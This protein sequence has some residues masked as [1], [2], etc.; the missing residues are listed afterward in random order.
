MKK[1]LNRFDVFSI[2][3]GSIIG[4]G[5]FMLP[6]TK[7]LSKAGVINTAIG[8]ILGTICIIIIEKNYRVMMECH[9]E[10]GGEFSFTYKYLGEKHGFIVGWFLIL[11]YLTMIPLNA[12]AFPLV[13]EKLFGGIL[14]FGY[15]YKIAGSPVYFGEVLTSAIVII[16]FAYINIKGIKSTSKIQNI[17]IILL[18]IMIFSVFIGMIFKTNKEVIISNYLNNY[19]FN[20]KEVLTIFAITPFAFIGFDAIPQLS[21]EFK[22]SPKKASMVAIISLSIGTLIYN[23]LNITTAMAYSR[24]DAILK[25]WA[26]G[27]A[28]F[29]FLGTFGFILLIIALTAAV[30]S[31]INGFMICTTKLIGSVSSKGMIWD[32]LSMKNKEGVLKNAIIFTSIIS[33]IAPWFGRE[34][35][36]VI[37]NMSSLGASIAYLYVSFIVFKNNNVF[38]KR[39]FGILGILI[40][41]LFIFLLLVPSSPASLKSVELFALSLWILFGGIFYFVKSNR[42]RNV[43][44]N[45]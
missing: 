14:K 5:A 11:A 16:L 34:V 33:L 23:I 39:I 43:N 22:F 9:R 41:S 29:E 24:N 45:N 19:S 2:V 1:Y 10:E 15:L 8:L 4:W 42:K 44:I 3:L 40:S 38:S 36:N 28:V 12:T 21:Q 13:V 32:R 17:I 35:I 27:S 25:H 7:F 31:G 18:V 6:G 20:L 30:I 26:L 37:V